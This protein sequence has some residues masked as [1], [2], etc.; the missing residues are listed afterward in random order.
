M[1]VSYSV[2][3]ATARSI[4]LAKADGHT[5]ALDTATVRFAQERVV[6][7]FAQ[8]WNASTEG[9]I[10]PPSEPSRAFTLIELLV[11]IAIIAV[12]AALLLP[13]LDKAKASAR[14]AK[15]IGNL[16]QIGIGMAMYVDDHTR[17]PF[18]VNWDQDSFYHPRTYWFDS[19]QP[20][21]KQLW[22]GAL[23]KCPDYRAT[24]C[25]QIWGR[26]GDLSMPSLEARARLNE[27]R[28]GTYGYNA[29][30]TAPAFPNAHPYGLGLGGYSTEST[31]QTPGVGRA[32]P[33]AAIAT[34]S[35]LILLTE[36]FQY[37]PVG[38]LSY[39]DFALTSPM[40]ATSMGAQFND[41]SAVKR[42]HNGKHPVA[43]VD[44]HVEVSRYEALYMRRTDAMLS[45]WNNDH[46]PHRELLPALLAN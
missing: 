43:F 28:I 12:L 39:S 22:T 30:G 27:P 6:F 33:A 17:Y 7:M 23:F 18:H 44:G 35:D 40:G 5:Q 37:D 32:V 41:T 36:A 20:Y 25:G 13:A 24:K 16:R 31:A 29:G 2:D 1:S 4:F 9:R 10:G 3:L 11:V 8:A 14:R 19:L 38:N 34:P 21:V 46:Q 15:C 45:R 26:P 42:R